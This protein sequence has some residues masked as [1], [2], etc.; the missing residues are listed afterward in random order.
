MSTTNLPITN[1]PDSAAGQKL[2]FDSYG[3]EPLA[4]LANDIESTTAF[5]ERNG[6]SRAAS[7]TIA[8]LLLKQAKLDNLSVSSIL[9]D[10]ERN[11][12]ITLNGFIAEVLNNN[13]SP[14]S[15]IG[16]RTSDISKET[17]VRNIFA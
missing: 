7:V 17:I 14:I 3:R 13:R 8:A 10:L 9:K 6:F 16:F 12:T 1:I 15:S 4:F 11:D 2:F 5:F